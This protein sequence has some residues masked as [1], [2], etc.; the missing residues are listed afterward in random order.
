[1]IETMQATSP[2]RTACSPGLAARD[3]GPAYELKF[4]LTAPEAEE[5]IAWA[6]QHLTPDP[7]GQD[8]AYRV[9]TLY[10]DTPH[11]D[12]FHRSPGFRRRKYRLRRYGES[13]RVYLERKCRQGDRV[14]KR[15]VEVLPQELPWLAASTPMLNWVG[16]WFHRGTRL[17]SL[18]PTC[19]VGYWR[20][21]FFGQTSSTP[22]RLT[23]DRELVGVPLRDW[24]VPFLCEGPELLP[25]DVLL[26]LKYHVHM[27]GL[28]HELLP[29]LPLQQ[30]RV[31]KYRRCVQVG[32]LHLS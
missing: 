27:P 10:C 16:D 19:G 17:R 6:R 22:V 25:G 8:G 11:L 26:E 31:S 28:F 13:E 5:V 14:R 23:I 29:R 18:R 24:S 3:L 2:H 21:A 4:H 9:T 15:R 7:N 20:T 12:V 30:A 1:M 32:G